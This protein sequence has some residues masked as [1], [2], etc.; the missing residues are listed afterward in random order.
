MEETNSIA[1]TESS[2]LDIKRFA[3]NSAPAYH[4]NGWQ[5][6]HQ[7]YI[8][9]S[10]SGGVYIDY[11]PQH[12]PYQ[13][14]GRTLCWEIDPCL[15]GKEINAL[16]D[17]IRPL[18]EIVHDGHSI[19][20]DGRNHHGVLSDEA[21]E[22][23]E[24]IIEICRYTEPS[25]EVSTAEEYLFSCLGIEE[26]WREGVSLEELVDET[27][28]GAVGHAIVLGDIKEAI[29]REAKL[30]FEESEYPL[31]EHILCAMRQEKEISEED[32]TRY[33]T[34]YAMS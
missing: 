29:L 27:K 15:S 31:P 8:S 2:A 28:R 21:K 33:R 4:P 11:G 10:E 17:K 20:W 7:A 19:E 26:V 23:D 3:D 1:I 18:L 34:E 9:M 6:P 25:Q 13:V 30:C 22:A 24:T 32:L 12:A 14:Y 16:I 5:G